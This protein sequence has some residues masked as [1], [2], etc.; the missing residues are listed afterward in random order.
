M[1]R[2]FLEPHVE[3]THTRS[4]CAYIKVIQVS[5]A[6]DCTHTRQTG[7]RKAG[8]TERRPPTHPL[9]R[10]PKATATVVAYM[11]TEC[12]TACTYIASARAATTATNAATEAASGEAPEV[13]PKLLVVEPRLPVV[14]VVAA[15]VAPV[16]T[17]T[18]DG[19]GA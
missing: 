1:F 7:T 14:A 8:S 5:Y 13:R 6:F 2:G 12:L 19:A 16:V 15:V 4:N 9:A 3:G 11:S 10:P 17:V 18:G